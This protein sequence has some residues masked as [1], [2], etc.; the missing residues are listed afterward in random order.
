MPTKRKGLAEEQTILLDLLKQLDLKSYQEVRKRFEKE[1]RERERKAAKRVKF[2][3]KT[4]GKRVSRKERLRLDVLPQIVYQA[5]SKG[6]PLREPV[7]KK[8]SAPELSPMLYQTLASSPLTKPLSPPEGGGQIPFDLPLETDVKYVPDLLYLQRLDAD[9]SKLIV[10]MAVSWGYLEEDRLPLFINNKGEE[11]SDNRIV[12]FRSDKT[13]HGIYPLRPSMHFQNDEEES[14]RNLFVGLITGLKPNKQY[15]YRIEC[16]EKTSRKL[17]AATNNIAFRT[18]FTLKD[19]N[20]PL[21]LTVS[22]DLH[23]GRGGK[24][25]RGKVQG[26]NAFGNLDLARVFNGI[27][28]TENEVTFQEGYTLAIA[29]G[30]LTENASYTEYWM[31]LFKCCAPLWNHVPLLTSIGNHDY[32][33]GGRRRGNVIGGLEEDC[34]YFHRFI[35]NPNGS[36]GNLPEHWYAIEFGNVFAI[37]LDTNGLG[38]GK[39]EIACGTEQWLWL[40]AE[41]KNWRERQRTNPKTP[42]FCFVFLHS[43]IMSLGFWGRGFNSGNDE[44]VQSYLTPLFRKY[45]VDMVFC[46][47]DHIYQRSSWMGTVYLENGRHGGSTRPYLFWKKRQ[48]VYDIEQICE[49]WNTRIYTSIYIPPNKELLTKEQRVRFESLKEHMKK[50]L[51]KQPT[52]SNFFFGSRK[53]NRLIGE[54]FDRNPALKAKLIEQ[55]V[56]PKLEDHVWFRAYALENKT[57]PNERELIDMMFLRARRPEKLIKIN[58]TLICPEIVVE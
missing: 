3:K 13:L 32:Y 9:S 10:K 37:F 28:A 21:F 51:L 56:L 31:D 1:Q 6:I 24:F 57:L 47:H 54:K 19:D 49:Q 2:L 40:E 11:Q 5:M 12:V 44:K 8:R 45:G 16:Y 35:T 46:G 55:L 36:A 23:G 4:Q 33:C 15:Y 48:V 39:Y 18:A 38:W 25:L 22:S 34:R 52:A 50:T 26:K 53:T 27:V 41:L 43:A 20:A 29:T 14:A 58:Y 42:Q 30:D 7:R 17:F